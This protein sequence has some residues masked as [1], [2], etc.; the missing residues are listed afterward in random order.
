MRRVSV[1]VLAVLVLTAVSCA[2][3]QESSVQP[4]QVDASQPTQGNGAPPDSIPEQFLGLWAT[5]SKRCVTSSS[6]VGAIF[7]EPR[8]VIF[9]GS[10]GQVIGVVAQD[11]LQVDVRLKYS[12]NTYEYGTEDPSQDKVLDLTLRLSADHKTVSIIDSSD[13]IEN[14]DVRYHCQPAG[15]EA[16]ARIPPGN[17]LQRPAVQ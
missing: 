8:K 7:V 16:P 3:R 2:P 17:S 5:T 13:T 12:E 11:D 6:D 4:S 14:K 1:A 9:W 10:S 15:Q